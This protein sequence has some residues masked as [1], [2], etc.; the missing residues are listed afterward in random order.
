MT[1]EKA[2]TNRKFTTRKLEWLQ[3]VAHDPKIRPWAFEVAFCIMTHLNEGNGR[4]WVSDETL[5]DESSSPQRTVR[6]ARVQLRDTG[7]LKWRRTSTANSY[8]PL[9]DKVS[10]TIDALVIKRDQRQE[11]RKIRRRISNAHRPKLAEHKPPDRP[12]LAEQE[13]PDMA[14]Q[15]RPKLADI[16]VR[17]NTLERTRYRTSATEVE[18]VDGRAASPR[19]LHH[20]SNLVELK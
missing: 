20:R 5:G 6:R 7:W 15:D 14:E 10:R 17:V 2:K 19:L 11:R 9:Y 13:R 3:C 8:E 16:H 18:V 1:D 12:K 4:S